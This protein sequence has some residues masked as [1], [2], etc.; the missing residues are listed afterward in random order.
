MDNVTKLSN[1]TACLIVNLNLELE[2]QN[3]YAVENILSNA[4]ELLKNPEVYKVILFRLLQQ[5][6]CTKEKYIPF[7]AKYLSIEKKSDDYEQLKFALIS[8]EFDEAKELIDKRGI[9]V[10]EFEAKRTDISWAIYCFSRLN[11]DVRKEMLELLIKNGL[12]LTYKEKN[13]NLLHIF[14]ESFAKKGDEDLVDISRLLVQFGISLNET[15][16][17]GSTVLHTTL[18]LF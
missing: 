18:E 13:E 6:K 7:L 5:E 4:S 16:F 3:L 12:N 9:N 10:A 2:K 11:M 8:G 15:N 17:F 1:Q 14:M